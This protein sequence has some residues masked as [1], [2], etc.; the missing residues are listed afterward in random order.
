MY[1]PEVHIVATDTSNHSEDRSSQNSLMGFLSRERNFLLMLG[2]TLIAAGVFYDQPQ[3]AMWIGFAIAGYSAIANDSIQTLGT[4]IASNKKT[5]WWMMWLFVGGIFV[6]TVG[7]SWYFRDG[8][9]SHGRLHSKGFATAPTEFAFLQVAAPIFLLILTR[10][11][12]PVSTTFLLLSCFTTEAKGFWAVTTKSLNGYVIAFVS[13]IIVWVIAGPTLKRIFQGKASFGWVIAQWVSAGFLWSVWLMQDAANIAVYLPRSLSTGEFLGFAGTI[14]FGLG[15]LMRMGG[16]KVQEVV[17][18]KSDVSDV[19]SATVINIIY[20]I[21][22]Y[23]FKV[24]SSVPMST[25][26]VFV[27]L[28]AGREIAI[29]LRNAGGEGRTLKMALKMAGKDLVYVTIGFIVAVIIAATTNEV[30]RD[31]L[32]K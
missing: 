28:L 17:D 23:I 10:L 30:V 20:G 12:M 3:I 31:A 1:K 2:L 7:Y 15:F 26:W 27:G 25:T 14:F 13:A 21:I 11:R 9:V 4:F 24:K 8:D 32:F 19:R 29:A 5:P 16:E 22:L 6:L 18:E